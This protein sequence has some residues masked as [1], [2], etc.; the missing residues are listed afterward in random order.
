M[1]IPELT[2]TQVAAGIAV[3]GVALVVTGIALLAG[4]AWAL[5]AAGS[6]GI[7]AAVLL[8]PTD[9]APRRARAGRRDRS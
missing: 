9:N 3:A 7:V 6:F 8:Y 5:I 4:A 1:G 2:M